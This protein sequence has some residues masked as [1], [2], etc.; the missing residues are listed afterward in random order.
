MDKNQISTLLGICIIPQVISEIKVY[1]NDQ[2][3][4][5]IKEFYKSTLYDKLQ[6]PA[7]GLW[8]LSAKTL[9]EIFFLEVKEK[10]LDYPEEQS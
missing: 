1:F 6:N 5:A 9:A 8:H 4:T 7:T 10:I 2:E 3:E